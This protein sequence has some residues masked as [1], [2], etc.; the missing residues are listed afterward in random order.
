MFFDYPQIFVLQDSHNDAWFLLFHC[1]EAKDLVI[2]VIGA[3]NW[4]P[5]SPQ[6]FVSPMDLIIL[7]HLE[8][9]I[10]DEKAK[11][12]GHP[13]GWS[14]WKSHEPNELA[15]HGRSLVYFLDRSSLAEILVKSCSVTIPTSL[16]SSTTSRQE[17]LR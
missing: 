13:L 4:V 2:A 15:A 12:H 7:S 14:N 3:V 8:S 1:C 6:V 5:G 9:I 17:S 11:M 10:E 16:S